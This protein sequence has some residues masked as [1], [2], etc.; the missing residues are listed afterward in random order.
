MAAA[1][2]EQRYVIFVCIIALGR[3]L[4]WPAHSP[5]RG[6]PACTSPCRRIIQFM[7]CTVGL[8]RFFAVLFLA[9][10]AFF[11]HGRR[12][13]RGRPCGAAPLP[14][15]CI[16]CR[17]CPAVPGLRP[18]C[19]FWGL[20]SGRRWVRTAEAGAGRAFLSFLPRRRC[21]LHSASA[22]TRAQRNRPHL[23]R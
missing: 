7:L 4:P 1:H 20:P 5:F 23:W 2:R 18:A 16:I 8:S 22:Q 13:Q 10:P 17:I 21:R 6:L 3:R 11:A 14:L 9:K 19:L 15:R 12:R